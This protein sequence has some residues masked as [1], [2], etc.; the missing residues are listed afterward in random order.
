[1]VIDCEGRVNEG[2]SVCSDL[3][4]TFTQ[5]FQVRAGLPE[6]RPRPFPFTPFP[7]LY[8]LS[9]LLSDALDSEL[10]PVLNKQKFKT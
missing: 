6:F 7:I 8:S 1:M 10:L 4:F 3:I 9:M 5:S 2:H